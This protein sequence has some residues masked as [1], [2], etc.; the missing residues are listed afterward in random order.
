LSA[1]ELKYQAILREQDIVREAKKQ[2]EH[3]AALAASA[4]QIERHLLGLLK[5]FAKAVDDHDD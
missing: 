1:A 5:L 4:A 3:L 2:T